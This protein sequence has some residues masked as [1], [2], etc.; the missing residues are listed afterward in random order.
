MQLIDAGSG[1]GDTWYVSGLWALCGAGVDVSRTKP[2]DAAS[3]KLQPH[4]TLHL[5]RAGKQEVQK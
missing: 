1:P 2:H 5:T 3:R 4:V